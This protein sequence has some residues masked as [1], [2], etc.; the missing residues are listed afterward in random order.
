MAPAEGPE[1]ASRLKATPARRASEAAP[2]NNPGDP[3]PERMRDQHGARTPK[4][5]TSSTAGDRTRARTTRRSGMSCPPSHG[6]R[7]WWVGLECACE[8][9]IRAAGCVEEAGRGWS[10][11]TAV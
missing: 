2:A 1:V 3:L 7:I 10:H 11:R 5:G 6:E 4:P 9:C 8:A